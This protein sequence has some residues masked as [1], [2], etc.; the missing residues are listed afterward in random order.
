MNGRAFS[1]IKK[2]KAAFCQFKETK[3]YSDYLEYVSAR[4]A[5]KSEICK[6]VRD[7]EKEIAKCAK[8][9]PKAFYRHANSKVT[10]SSYS[11]LK[12]YLAVAK[13]TV[14]ALPMY[15]FILRTLEVFLHTDFYRGNQ[16]KMM[17]PVFLHHHIDNTIST[18]KL[19]ATADTLMLAMWLQCRHR[20]FVSVCGCR[21]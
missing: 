8:T 10:S 11:F 19:S 14:G 15:S 18:M 12:Q 20:V 21:L 7:Y 17:V 16:K 4:N 13:C 9:N 2:K 6:A 5:A 1:K 3:Q